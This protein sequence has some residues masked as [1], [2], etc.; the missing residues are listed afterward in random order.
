MA[1]RQMIRNTVVLLIFLSQSSFA[2]QSVSLEGL[3]IEQAIQIAV[4]RNHDL[5]L[6]NIAVSNAKA[7]SVI[8]SATPNPTLT[9]QTFNI[10][11]GAGIG[12]GSLRSKTVDS[13]VRIDQLIERGDKRKFRMENSSYLEEAARNDSHDALRQLRVGVSQSYY[14]VLAAEEKLDIMRQTAA[15]Y[16]NTVVAAQKRQKAGDIANADVA[17]LQVDALRAQN[18]AAQAAADTSKARQT[19]AAMLGQIDYA[20]RIKLADSWPTSRFSAT[21]PSD[22]SIERRADVLAAKSRLDAAMTA[23]K[24]AL[25]ARTRDVSIGVQYEH[26]P[27]SF[28]NPQGGGNSYGIAVQIPLFVRYEFDGEIRAAEAGVDA[29]QEVLEKA[30]DQA[31]TEL[32]KNWE[33]AHTAGERVNRFD[34]SLLPA[35]KKSADSAEFAFKHGALSIMDVLDVR[36]TYRATQLD[37]IAA[38]VDYAKSLAAWQATLSESNTQ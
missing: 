21:T 7:A 6:S 30:R 32:M 18:D 11:P 14:E 20:K 15:L 38:R 36:R 25:A 12:A 24:L 13:T 27:A 23:R 28:A 33:D 29:A 26:F 37:A 3:T 8:A 4:E 16:D 10:N 31:R 35:A 22:T 5:R 19:L 9:V 1:S 17:R 34:E 2:T